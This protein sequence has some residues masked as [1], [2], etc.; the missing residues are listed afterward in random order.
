M[1]A[2]AAEGRGGEVR[3]PGLWIG[4]AAWLLIAYSAAFVGRMVTAPDFYES[5]A[6][7]AWAPPTALF[8]PVWTVLYALIG[9]SAWLVWRRGGFGAARAALTL[10]LVQHALN[11]LWSWIFFGARELGWAFAE[12]AVLWLLIA[13]TIAAFGRHSA[14]AAGLLAPYFVW[15]TYAAALNFALWRMNPA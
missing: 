1:E 7:P 5:L 11:A 4:L 12:I 9:I 8:G 3:A 2:R 6:Q 13:A 14:A 15:V 10:F